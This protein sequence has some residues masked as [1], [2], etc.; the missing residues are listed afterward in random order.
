M[1]DSLFLASLII[2]TAFGLAADG[3]WQE[4]K[5]KRQKR[6]AASKEAS[7]TTETGAESTE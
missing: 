6:K 7:T 4:R 5:A 1:K 3:W 2:L